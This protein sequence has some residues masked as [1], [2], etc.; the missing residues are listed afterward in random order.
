MS[1]DFSDFHIKRRKDTKP[2]MV[3]LK[4][5]GQTINIM[6]IELISPFCGNTVLGKF[7]M[8]PTT[9]DKLIRL[10]SCQVDIMPFERLSILIK[11]IHSRNHH[12]ILEDCSQEERE[13]V[14]KELRLCEVSL[15]DTLK[16]TS[17]ENESLTSNMWI[18]NCFFGDVDIAN[19][20]I[21][22]DNDRRVIVA[23]DTVAQNVGLDVLINNW[24]ATAE[25]FTEHYCGMSLNDSLQRL[26]MYYITQMKLGELNDFM[27]ETMITLDKTKEYKNEVEIAIGKYLQEKGS[28]L[29]N[30]VKI[31]EYYNIN[32]NEAKS[33]AITFF[34]SFE[35]PAEIITK[36]FNDI[37]R[38]EWK[39]TKIRSTEENIDSLKTND[40]KIL[41]FLDYYHNVFGIYLPNGLVE[42]DQSICLFTLRNNN[43]IPYTFISSKQQ[44]HLSLIPEGALWSFAI[45]SVLY[46]RLLSPFCISIGD[47][48]SCF[49]EPTQLNEML[50]MG[51][52]EAMLKDIIVFE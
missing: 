16:Y 37:G 38:A 29:N 14:A 1:M 6:Y 5:E 36:L 40:E 15:Q 21:K 39:I 28:S 17:L 51:T 23:F 3:Q 46:F 45:N 10:K 49:N 11:Y 9:Q 13:K 26:K 8:L 27:C 30:M 33:K 7:I 35:I 47:I 20:I 18:R 19:V 48:D 12:Q 31:I 52:S 42:S 34:F 24:R 50:F 22:H 41:I 32:V 2:G 44:V 25:L 4:C 43:N